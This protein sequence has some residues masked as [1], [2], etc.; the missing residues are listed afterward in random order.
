MDLLNLLGFIAKFTGKG[1]SA[2]ENRLIVY[3]EEK[4]EGLVGI[5]RGMGEKWGSCSGVGVQGRGHSTPTSHPTVLPK[6]PT[7]VRSLHPRPPTPSL[8]R[9]C[10]LDFG[11]C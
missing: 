6:G 11:S 5:Q 10:L 3:L 8:G 7:Q 2:Q 4:G 9:G 1:S